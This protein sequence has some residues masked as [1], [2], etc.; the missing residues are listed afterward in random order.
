M[1]A[2][3]EIGGKQYKV[4]KNDEILVDLMDV[5]EGAKVSYETVTLYRDDK[6]IVV[7]QPYCDKVKLEAQVVNPLVKGEKVIV[8]KYRCKVKYR[9]KTGHRQKYTCIKVTDIKKTA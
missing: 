1:Y 3:V 7:G 8:F 4:E 5:K 2:I 6:E 9:R